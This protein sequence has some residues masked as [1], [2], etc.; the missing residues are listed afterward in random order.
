MVG[1]SKQEDNLV[2]INFFFF[3]EIIGLKIKKAVSGKK[4]MIISKKQ[5]NLETSLKKVNFVR[6]RNRALN[7]LLGQM[8]ILSILPIHQLLMQKHV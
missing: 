5:L 4:Q 8:L 1:N 2:K 7:I 6:F 3:R